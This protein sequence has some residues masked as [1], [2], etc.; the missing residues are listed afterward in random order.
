MEEFTTT[1]VS[2]TLRSTKLMNVR[3]QCTLAGMLFMTAAA[4][5]M[6]SA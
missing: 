1:P 2:P 4:L 3:T 5:S 6:I